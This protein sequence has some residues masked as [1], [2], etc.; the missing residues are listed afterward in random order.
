MDTCSY[1]DE[2]DAVQHFLWGCNNTQAFWNNVCSWFDQVANF[3]INISL[4]EFLFGVP[5][6]QPGARVTNHVVL[7][8]KFYIYHQKLFHNGDMSLPH[9]LNKLRLKL[10]IERYKRRLEN[11][12][13]KFRQ[14][15]QIFAAL[16]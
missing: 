8:A 14:W 3:V 4:Q 2:P 13:Q 6:S 16:G 7:M 9:F 1:C 15:E 12:A 10:Q 5:P 11:K